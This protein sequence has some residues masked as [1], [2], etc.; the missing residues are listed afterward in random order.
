MAVVANQA[1]AFDKS[2]STACPHLEDDA[3]SG[4][5]AIPMCL[6]CPLIGKFDFQLT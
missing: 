2:M 5:E 1:V 6:K 4:S 3:L